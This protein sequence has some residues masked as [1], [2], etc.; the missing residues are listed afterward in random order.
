MRAKYSD[1]DFLQKNSI[2]GSAE[3]IG[4]IVGAYCI[5]PNIKKID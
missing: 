1:S 4:S 2:G 3:G 5:G